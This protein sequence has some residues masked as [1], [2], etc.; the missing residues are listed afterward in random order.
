L[1][2][3]AFWVPLTFSGRSSQQRLFFA[4][5]EHVATTSPVRSDGYEDHPQMHSSDSVAGVCTQTYVAQSQLV[6]KPSESRS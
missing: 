2:E 1:H 3:H 5:F 4:V 6:V